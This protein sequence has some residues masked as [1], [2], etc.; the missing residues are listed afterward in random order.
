V[1]ERRLRRINADIERESDRR[2][3]ELNAETARANLELVR[4]KTP[5]IIPAEKET[6][7]SNLLRGLAGQEF[8]LYSFSDEESWNLTAAMERI[9]TGAGWI[10]KTAT[11]GD[12]RLG[13]YG[14][15]TH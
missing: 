11:Q 15:T 3:A 14:V 1:A 4:L 12:I 10:F 13:Q 2:I 9:L 5:Q 6:L 8:E 7:L